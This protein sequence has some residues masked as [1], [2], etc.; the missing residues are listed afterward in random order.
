VAIAVLLALLV[1]CG[2]MLLFLLA[3]LIYIA[4][5]FEVLL[6]VVPVLL[7]NAWLR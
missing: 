2:L 7:V 4:L 6:V 3:G 1:A 5:M